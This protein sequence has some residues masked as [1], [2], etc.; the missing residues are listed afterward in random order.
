AGERDLQLVDV[1]ALD[2]IGAEELDLVT[3]I[4]VVEERIVE[5]RFLENAFRLVLPERLGVFLPLPGLDL[6]PVLAVVRGHA[7]H[8]AERELFA[9]LVRALRLVLDLCLESATTVQLPRSTNAL[10][11]GDS[12]KAANALGVLGDDLVYG[13]LRSER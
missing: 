12:L 6:P 13:L 1:G 11:G 2:L 4:P 8:P 9:H 3:S 5:L 10:D 7:R